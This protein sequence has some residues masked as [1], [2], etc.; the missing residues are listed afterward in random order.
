MTETVD[1]RILSGHC[2]RC[3]EMLTQNTPGGVNSRCPTCSPP[4]ERPQRP[5]RPPNE[6]VRED[7]PPRAKLGS[8]SGPG[9]VP[10]VIAGALLAAICLGAMLFYAVPLSIVAWRWWIS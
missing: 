3:G 10:L 2:W 9:L 1:P 8:Y 7:R 4:F 6:I 5:Q